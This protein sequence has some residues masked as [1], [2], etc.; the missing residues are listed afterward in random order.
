MIQREIIRQV[1]GDEEDTIETVVRHRESEFLG[2]S[3]YL[4][5]KVAQ[6]RRV[7]AKRKAEARGAATVISSGVP[8]LENQ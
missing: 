7:Q 1:D 2:R 4:V 6:G 3:S 8:V 5:A